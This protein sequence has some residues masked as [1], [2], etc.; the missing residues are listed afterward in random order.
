MED[1]LLTAIETYLSLVL[2][3]GFILYVIQTTKNIVY[4]KENKYNMLAKSHMYIPIY[5]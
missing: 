4:E 5:K 1:P 3:L 2:M